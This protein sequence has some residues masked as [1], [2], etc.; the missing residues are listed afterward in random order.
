VANLASN[1][2]YASGLR[3]NLSDKERKEFEEIGKIYRNFVDYIFLHY[4]GIS[5]G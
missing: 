4:Y 5:G 2:A 3:K 1:R